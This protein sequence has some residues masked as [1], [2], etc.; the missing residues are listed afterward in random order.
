MQN[1]NRLRE[2][3]NS[4]KHN[5]IHIIGTSEEEREEEVENL[6]EDIITENFPTLGKEINIQIQETEIPQQNQPRGLTKTHS[7]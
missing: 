1:Q 7:N 5:N 4:V 2:L 6:F 3:S